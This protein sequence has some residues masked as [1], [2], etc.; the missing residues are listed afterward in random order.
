MHSVKQ[1]YSYGTMLHKP[2]QY[3]KYDQ[4]FADAAKGFFNGKGLPGVYTYSEP[5]PNLPRDVVN[6]G[7][8]FRDFVK[9]PFYYP[10]RNEEKLLPTVAP[11]I[12]QL[13][14]YFNT[15]VDLGC[16]DAFTRKVKY[17]IGNANYDPVDEN[18]D[19]L[20]EVTKQYSAL[21]PD[22]DINEK[23]KQHKLN[24][25]TDKISISGT[26]FPIML[27]STITNFGTP[28]SVRQIFKQVKPIAEQGNGSFVF[29][30]DTNTH[31]D[32]LLRTYAHELMQQ[33]TLNV[34]HRMKRDLYTENFDP[35]AFGFHAYWE[36]STSSLNICMYP[37]K[38]MTKGNAFAIDGEWFELEKGQMLIQ[39]SLMKLPADMMQ[40]LA[41]KEGFDHF[42]PIPDIDGHIALQHMYL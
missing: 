18:Q 33:H 20:D 31:P 32:S 19:Y 35:D 8:L 27:G 12:L 29:S 38:G 15:L 14:G 41:K 36:G 6:G 30:H 16:G 5:D 7:Q 23:I 22:Q 21:Y 9:T 4:A 40:E 34:L 10:K 24:F 17:F 3:I 26:P 28:E 42:D 1:L 11:T 37:L 2:Q 39:A 13:A 25:M